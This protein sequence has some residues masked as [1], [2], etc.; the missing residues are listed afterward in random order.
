[1][2]THGNKSAFAD[3]FLRFP[4]ESL[5]RALRYSLVSCA[6]TVSAP[7]H[8][9]KW[10]WGQELELLTPGVYFRMVPCSQYCRNF[11]FLLF[12]GNG[13]GAG[14]DSRGGDAAFLHRS[15]FAEHARKT[16]GDGVDDSERWYF[17]SASASLF[18]N[19]LPLGLNHTI[20]ARR[21]MRGFRKPPFGGLRNPLLSAFSTAFTT[22]KALI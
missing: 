9:R 14:V 17:A 15:I 2:R 20:T 4:Y 19:C 16:A 1:M 21:F 12:I 3:A 13:F 11:I 22:G 6:P 10:L 18:V 7:S 8:P 5:P